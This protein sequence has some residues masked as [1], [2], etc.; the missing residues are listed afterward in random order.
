MSERASDIRIPPYAAT[1]S[2]TEAICEH[3]HDA[4]IM[5]VCEQSPVYV[6]VSKGSKSRNRPKLTTHHKQHNKPPNIHPLK[7]LFCTRACVYQDLCT[8]TR[9]T[10]S[11]RHSDHSNLRHPSRSRERCSRHHSCH[12]LCTTEKR[13]HR[14]WR[15]SSMSE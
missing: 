4:I 10:K 11:C 6:S 14:L 12:R 8:R 7:V 1:A 13:S 15:V 9:N 2:V 3:A 5:Q